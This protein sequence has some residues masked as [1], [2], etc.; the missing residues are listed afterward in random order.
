MK[1]GIGKKISGLSMRTKRIIALCICCALL[2]LA[3]FQNIRSNSSDSGKDDGGGNL[4]VDGGSDQKGDGNVNQ[5]GPG[6]GTESGL[7]ITL[8][9]NPEEY[10][11]SARLERM[12]NRSLAEEAC[13]HVVN[14]E[15]ASEEEKASAK[16]AAET[17]KL[18]GEI[19]TNI[20]TSILSRGYEDALVCL[21]DEGYVDITVLADSL[22]ESEVMTLA[23]L[24]V[25]ATGADYDMIVLRGIDAE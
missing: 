19:E 3:I 24:A 2:A 11:A 20:E 4:V 12:N 15:E 25:E 5:E 6:E 18:M 16:E 23:A 17:L 8:V 9:S 22:N 21:D 14:S 13:L 10:F 7:G 1:L